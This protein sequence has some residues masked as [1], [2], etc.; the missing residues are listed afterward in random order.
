M[1]KFHYK[2]NKF[3]LLKNL[4]LLLFRKKTYKIKTKTDKMTMSTNK[5]VDSLILE[6][7]G[8]K[9]NFVLY[10]AHLLI[11][12]FLFDA[13]RY[14]KMYGF[15]VEKRYVNEVHCVNVFPTRLKQD[16]F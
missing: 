12:A 10:N 13:L 9:L 16:C 2:S 5:I 8:N 4:S 7:N 6:I 11:N 14:R 1:I 3:Q 15:R